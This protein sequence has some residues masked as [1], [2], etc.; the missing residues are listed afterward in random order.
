MLPLFAAARHEHS[1]V[2]PLLQTNKILPLSQRR[3]KTNLVF[4]YD[5][6]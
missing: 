6:V 1:I 4:S 2:S 5:S 3:E